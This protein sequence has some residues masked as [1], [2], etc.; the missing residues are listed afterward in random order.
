MSR[1]YNPNLFLGK[2]KILNGLLIAGM[3]LLF[4]LGYVLIQRQEIRA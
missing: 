3:I 1:K 4:A 2:I